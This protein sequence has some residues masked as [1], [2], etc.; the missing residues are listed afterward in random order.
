[1][2]WAWQVAWG[3]GLLLN[4]L[5]AQVSQSTPL[6]YVKLGGRAYYE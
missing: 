1:M 2:A 3:Q 6:Y 4:Q 5:K